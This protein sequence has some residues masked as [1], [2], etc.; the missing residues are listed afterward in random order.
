LTII[1]GSRKRYIRGA[2]DWHKDN[3]DKKLEFLLFKQTGFKDFPF[4]DIREFQCGFFEGASLKKKNG[5]Y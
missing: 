3:E 2:I 1:T 4:T 5:M